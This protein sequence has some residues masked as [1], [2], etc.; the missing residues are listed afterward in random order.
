L[1]KADQPKGTDAGD[2]RHTGLVESTGSESIVYD[3]LREAG[4]PSDGATRSDASGADDQLHFRLP[5]DAADTATSA[6]L[7]KWQALEEAAAHVDTA[8]AADQSHAHDAQNHTTTTDGW[9][10]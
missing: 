7:T 9:L 5:S 4:A 10:L 1:P 3:H 8:V 2:D 6:T